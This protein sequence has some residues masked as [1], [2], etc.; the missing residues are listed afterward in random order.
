M[1]DFILQLTNPRADVNMEP[2]LEAFM[3]DISKMYE[4]LNK[5]VGITIKSSKQ[6]CVKDR[7]MSWSSWI[8][9]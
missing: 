9:H 7:V 5:D 1:S 6:E 2:I 8:Y 3:L 4:D